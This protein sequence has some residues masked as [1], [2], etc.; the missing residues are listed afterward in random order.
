M[1]LK[2][3]CLFI[4]GILFAHQATAE[5]YIVKL[6]PGTSAMSY[7]L[8]NNV[9][10]K[11][12]S[13]E[14][15]LYQATSSSTGVRSRAARS[16]NTVYAVPNHVV[17]LRASILPNDPMVS[18]QWSLFLD[19]DNVGVGMPEAWRQFGYGG[20]DKNYNDIV[21]AI[22]DGGFDH[23]HSDLIANRW[24][25]KREIAGNGKDD[26]GNGYI[27]DINGW[28][29]RDNN[30]QIA[31]ADHGTHVAG[32]I[33][34][35][36]H[37]KN[38]VSGVNQ[39]VKMM[40]VSAGNGLG[41]TITTMK[42]YSYILKQKQMWLASGGKQGANVVAINSSF[43]IDAQ[44][45]SDPDFAVWDDMIDQLGAAGILSIAATSNLEINVDKHGDVPT[46]CESPF[47]IAV[48]NNG[49]SGAKSTGTEWDPTK[50]PFPSFMNGGAGFGVNHI[51]LA[52]PGEDVLS[53]AQKTSFSPELFTAQS[54]TSFSTPHVAGAVG[55]LHSVAPKAFATRALQNPAEA[56]LELKEVILSSVTKIPSLSAQTASGGVL[57]I[58]AASVLINQQNLLLTAN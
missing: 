53:T 50:T 48:T 37:N 44:Q 32:I 28:N 41:D 46:S 2:R 21:V 58:Y 16:I 42:A 47:L 55:Y 13:A 45:C 15:G 1:S 26:D 25:N 8:Q 34:A 18:E 57:N 29:A 12:I 56:A 27:D 10:L 20:R 14:L 23:S 51:D 9:K 49:K 52:A 17:K 35:R 33:G 11:A 38:G 19:T 39:R 40:Y 7:Q 4:A 36:G 30:N 6:Q 54:G 43:G 24:V 5:E 3:T 31:V 22:V